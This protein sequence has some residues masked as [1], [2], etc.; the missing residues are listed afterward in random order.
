MIH[1]TPGQHIH[2]VGIGGTGLSA[3]ARVLL[4][5][6]Y[7]VSGS[8]RALNAMTDA[9]A[10]DGAR[11]YSGHAAENID[12]AD[13]LMI[14]SAVQPDHVE[15][16]A[17]RARGIPVYKRSDMIAALMQGKDC[18]AV[19]GTHGKT[20]T[21]A[22][23]THILQT[24]GRDPSYIIGGT[25]RSSGQNAGVGAGN[26][27]VIEADEYDNMFLGLRPKVAIVNNVEW[28]HPD[29]FPTPE[30]LMRSFQS[31]ADLL[32]AD[33]LLIACADDVGSLTLSARMDYLGRRTATYS[34][35]NPYA[36]W[37]AV[38]LRTNA[39]QQAFVVQ[40]D[41]QPVGSGSLRVPGRHNVLNALAA[42]IAADSQGVPVVEALSALATYE[43]TGRRFDLRGEAGGVAV[44]D[45]YAHHPTAIRATIEAARERYPDR[46]LWA[47]WQ[48]HTY[49][50]T[51]TLMDDYL[52]AF[53]AAHH[54]VVTDI[55][56]ARE[57][58]VP[59]VTSAALVAHFNHPD[60]AHTPTLEDAA[61]L[62]DERVNAPAVILIM[63][64]GDAPKIGVEFLKRRQA[65]E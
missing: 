40:I 48:P 7:V 65:G 61:N 46:E 12:G 31:F 27:F 3:I 49:S 35:E 21:T 15:V 62:L 51:Q 41:G 14:S 17:A 10:A 59:G 33:G 16:Q 5:Q 32:P 45:D 29:F 34:V 55:Y 53:D 20:T 8:D 50:R 36:L 9:L 64:A 54:V 25:L 60:A 39:G 30:D 2:L 6:G 28:D 42:M 56:A 47:V 52:T 37:R 1:L 26:A 11:I 13:A 18:L 63:S 22:M 38:D 43:G 58:P 23:L 19:A 24:T 44:I 4:G 57:Q